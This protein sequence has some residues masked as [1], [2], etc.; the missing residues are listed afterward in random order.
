VRENLWAMIRAGA[1][2]VITYHAR[3]V[4]KEKWL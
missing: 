3:E 2:A 4:L 1:D